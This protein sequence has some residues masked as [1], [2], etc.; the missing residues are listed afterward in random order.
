MRRDICAAIIALTLTGAAPAAAAELVMFE[1]AGCPYCARFDAEVGAIYPK[2]DEARRAPL[3]RVDI[4]AERPA[5]LAEIDPGGFTP[6][7]VLV[8]DGHER[9]RIRG[10]PGE[11]N[12]YGMLDAMLQ[13]LDSSKTTSAAP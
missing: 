7:F 9:G 2:T 11:D 4:H 5:D 1:R 10:Y 12:F 13:D 8:E 3:R 6:T